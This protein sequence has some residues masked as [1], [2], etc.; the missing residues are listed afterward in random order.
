MLNVR[1]QHWFVKF[2]VD[3]LFEVKNPAEI[4]CLGADITLQIPHQR[5][6]KLLLLHEGWRSCSNAWSRWN[7]W[8]LADRFQASLH[9]KQPWLKL[10]VLLS[11][12]N[13]FWIHQLFCGACIELFGK[14]AKC[15]YP[16]GL[17]R[18]GNHCVT[19]STLAVD[20]ETLLHAFERPLYDS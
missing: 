9:R 1:L 15:M 6:A 3:G 4:A 20:W 19:K 13:F 16:S 10:I 7:P 14:L 5:L 8:S 17:R 11:F 18:T 2:P 12:R